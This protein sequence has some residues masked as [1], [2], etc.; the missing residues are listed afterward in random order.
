[1]QKGE[2]LMAAQ[3]V[4]SKDVFIPQLGQTVEEVVL[5]G[6]LVADGAKV[7]F[8]DPVLE[9]ETD[10]AVFSVEANANGFIHFGPHQMG[11]TVPVLTVVAT[12]GKRDEGFAPSGDQVPVSEPE[13][14]ETPEQAPDAA[15]APV[16]ASGQKSLNSPHRLKARKVFAS[17]RARR[18]AREKSVDLARVTPSGGEGVR[19][20]EE[21]VI[22]YLGQGTKA[23]PI[24]AALAQEV[25]LDLR[26]VTGTGPQG[27]VTRADVEGAIR[28]RLSS[29][30]CCCC[31]RCHTACQ[32]AAPG[33]C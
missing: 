8:G 9:V 11:E 31:A 25:G 22:Q 13:V 19:V 20:V 18:L 3:N 10:K 7:D 16:Q 17:P 32:G 14:E 1:V 29:S 23:T 2:E 24:A 4:L 21:D 28:T 33:G 5:I 12:I 27:A 30:G 26:T 15:E 6:W